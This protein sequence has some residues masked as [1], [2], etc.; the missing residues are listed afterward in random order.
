MHYCLHFYIRMDMVS[1]LLFTVTLK[2]KL[3]H[4]IHCNTGSCVQYVKNTHLAKFLP[5]TWQTGVPVAIGQTIVLSRGMANRQK[6]IRGTVH[7]TI[8]TQYK[9]TGAR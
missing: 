3:H 4:F 2:Q 1:A 6:R 8:C 7:R 5:A 9:Q